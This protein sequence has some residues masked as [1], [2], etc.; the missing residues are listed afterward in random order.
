[1]AL[2]S[3][4][5]IRTRS[6]IAKMREAGR[7]VGE[8][9]LELCGAAVAGTTTGELDQLARRLIKKRGVESSFLGY[10]PYGLPQYPAVVCTSVNSEIVHGIPGA[11]ELKDGD[12]LSIDFGVISDGFHGDSAA[13]VAVGEISAESQRLLDVTAGSLDDAIA[14][15]VPGNRL[16][17]IGHAVQERAEGAGYSVV[18]QFVGHGIGRE[19]HEAPQIPNYGPN[20]RGPRLKPGMVFAIEPMVNVGDD[21]VRILDDQWTAVTADASLSAHFEHTILISDEGPEVLTRVPGSH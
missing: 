13:T 2:S 5:A 12:L 17:D 10:G 11:C 14:Q 16:S 6:E 15:M 1:M 8:I 9:L 20:G 4:I 3:S 19:L 7:H 21:E 18:K